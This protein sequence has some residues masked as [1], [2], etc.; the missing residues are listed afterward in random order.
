MRDEIPDRAEPSDAALL[1]AIGCG[2]ERA[3][4]ALYDR[5]GG[6]AYALARRILGRQDVAETVVK[7]TFVD[8]WRGAPRLAPECGGIRA[9]LLADVRRRAVRRL[10]GATGPANPGDVLGDTP[11]DD[12]W[13]AAPLDAQRAGV[14]R[15]LLALPAA[16]RRAIEAAYFAG[17]TQ[18]ELAAETSVA[19]ARVRA[20]L[21]AGLETLR[22]SLMEARPEAGGTSPFPGELPADAPP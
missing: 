4:A 21:R 6:L 14:R 3:L 16:Q 15:G 2:D 7:D 22:Q 12:P 18:T 11:V 13:G 17:R 5:Y 10:S 1:G 19:P 20:E 8:L 9:A